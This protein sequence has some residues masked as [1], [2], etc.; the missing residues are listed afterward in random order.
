MLILLLFIQRAICEQELLLQADLDFQ[1]F[2]LSIQIGTP[3]VEQQLTFQIGQDFQSKLGQFLFDSSIKI[4]DQS[5]YQQYLSGLTLYNMKKSS[6]A[7]INHLQIVKQPSSSDEYMQYV[8]GNIVTDILQVDNT[9]FKYTFLSTDQQKYLINR[10]FNGVSWL[11]RYYNNIFDDMYSQHTIGTRYYLMSM[12]LLPIN[13][14]GV[15]LKKMRLRQDLDQ[16]SDNYK[17]ASNIMIKSD[18]FAIKAYGIYLSGEDVTDKL[19]NRS[20][21]FDGLSEQF[22]IP[23]ELYNIV[24]LDQ[25]VKDILSGASIH[26]C[27]DC[28]C[29]K[30]QKLPKIKVITEEYIFEIPPEMYTQFIINPYNLKPYCQ[31]SIGIFFIFQ[32]HTAT[33]INKKGFSNV[34]KRNKQP[35][36]YW[37]SNY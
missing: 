25:D 5:F 36:I 17:Y 35:K 16:R 26:D 20:I 14:D 12:Q 15:R 23:Q 34:L 27:K 28:K 1:N 8:Q 7:D 29:S 19:K 37:C 24:I 32:F 6:S 22:M 30:I 3:L 2:V 33:F 13:D 9:K 31:I 4:N 21:N 18:Y 10:F 11:N